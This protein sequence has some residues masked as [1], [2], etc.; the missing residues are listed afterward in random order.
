MKKILLTIA[1][2]A[3]AAFGANAQLRVEAGLNSG[4]YSFDDGMSTYDLTA[5]YGPKLAV[6]YTLCGNE[7]AGVEAGLS[8][9]QINAKNETLKS[10]IS[11]SNIQIP[12]RAFYAFALGNVS[13]VPGIGLYAGY[14]LGGKTTLADAV[15][16][17]PFEGPEGLKKF[18]LGIDDEIL[19]GFGEHFTAGIG[20]QNSLFNLCKDK[21]VKTKS[22]SLFI[23]VGW[24]F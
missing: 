2:I 7:R 18:D 21:D 23:T 22:T 13:I 1:L 9:A 19:L 4:W 5:G 3:A 15:E 20:T 12:V 24:R 8:F 17:D 16:N 6:Y 10:K 11:V 14:G